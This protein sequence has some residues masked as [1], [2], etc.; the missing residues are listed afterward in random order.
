M[1]PLIAVY[2]PILPHFL[3]KC[4][5]QPCFCGLRPSIPSL[6]PLDSYRDVKQTTI[7]FCNSNQGFLICRF[8]IFRKSS[9]VIKKAVMLGLG[10]TAIEQYLILDW[11]SK[12]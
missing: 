8:M 4:R 12:A 11:L 9:L 3:P 10:P 6:F 1:M 5:F 2:P 7:R